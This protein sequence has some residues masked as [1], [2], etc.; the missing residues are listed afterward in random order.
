MH[1]KIGTKIKGSF[2]VLMLTIL[3]TAIYSVLTLNNGMN[4]LS[5]ISQD[6]NPVIDVL[7]QYRNLIK[8]SRA[9]AT[10]WVYVSA[11]DADKEK[12]REIHST[13]YPKIRQRVQEVQEAL[14][15]EEGKQVYADLLSQSD[16]LFETQRSVMSSLQSFENYEDAMVKF[17]AEDQIENDVIPN[18]DVIIKGI[19]VLIADQQ[20]QLLEINGEMLNSFGGLQKAIWVSGILGIGFALIISFWLTRGITRPINNVVENLSKLSKGMIPEPVKIETKDEMG[21]IGLGLNTLI[22]GFKS[23]SQ[24]AEKIKDG[25]L[26]AD[27]KLLSSDDSLGKVL[28][29]MRENLKRVIDETNTAVKK[30]ADEGKLDTR[31]TMDYDRGAWADLCT[32]INALFQSIAAPIKAIESIL[33]AMADGDLTQ[34]Y[35]EE[36]KGEI[37]ALTQSLNYALDNLNDF[38]KEIAGTANVVKDSSTSM[39]SSGEE[40]SSSTTEIASAIAQMSNGAQSQVA[41][42]DES[43]QLVETILSSSNEMAAKA[44]EINTAAKSGVLDSERGLE[45]VDNVTSSITQIRDFSAKT[46]QA[47]KTLIERSSEI[48][49]VLG[50]I[51]DIA[52]QTNLLALN[53]AIEAAQA[54]DA[55][56]GFAV[57]AEEIRKLAEDSRDSAKE[58]EKLIADVN[59]DTEQTA[60]MIE[61]MGESVEQGVSASSKATEVFKDM[62]NSSHK[63]L[64]HSEDILKSTKEQSEKIAQVVSITESIVVIAEQTSVGTEEV[65]SSSSQLSAGMTNYIDK[66]ERLNNI[67]LQLE[68]G[69]SRFKLDQIF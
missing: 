68:K 57:V 54:G 69:L 56:R 9:Y 36:A 12:L 23:T 27:Y 52:S 45:M 43:S 7:T 42:V 63:T 47:M 49:R 11:Y 25:N 22:E 8:D 59:S 51:T 65:A 24:F 29:A 35:K 13:G 39:L 40:M 6:L 60:L 62:A 3:F 34:R 46:N 64:S 48:E 32:S 30:V 53:A 19:E 67:S 44:D 66:S 21:T 20:S 14:T 1:F 58:I 41:Q 18:S 10:N 2:L 28:I 15:D 31:L 16:L 61:G 33:K 50:V 4:S 38:L 37:L 26:E 55:G 17:M 5:R